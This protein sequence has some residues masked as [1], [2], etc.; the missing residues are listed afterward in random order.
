MRSLFITLA[1]A[2][3]S[4]EIDNGGPYKLCVYDYYGGEYS[5]SVKSLSICPLTVEVVD[6]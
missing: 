6:G 3:F 2:F 1:V 4:H 5:I